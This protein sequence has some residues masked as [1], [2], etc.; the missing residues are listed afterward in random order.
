MKTDLPI[1]RRRLPAL[2]ALC[3]LPFGAA[4]PAHASDQATELGNIVVT[5]A[6]REQALKDAPASITVVTR[7][8]LA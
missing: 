3:C 5:A 1:P 6:S 7:E 2:L 4:A 8:A